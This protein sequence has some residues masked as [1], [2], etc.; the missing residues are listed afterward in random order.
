MPTVAAATAPTVVAEG[1][2][3]NSGNGI[4]EER[5]GR[6]RRRTAAERRDR[7]VGLR[8]TEVPVDTGRGRGEVA[9][10]CGG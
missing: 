10:G 5:R 7:A 9:D 3:E 4:E 1:A 8:T 6:G 2:S